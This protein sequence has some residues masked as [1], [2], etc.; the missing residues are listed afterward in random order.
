MSPPIEDD[1]IDEDEEDRIVDESSGPTV[2]LT[3]G[4]GSDSFV[5]GDDVDHIILSGTIGQASDFL[6]EDAATFNRRTQS[7][8]ASSTVMISAEGM[9]LM[10]ATAVELITI[11]A[12]SA[13]DTLTIKGDF[14]ST[15]LATGGVTFNGCGDAILDLDHLTSDLNVKVTR[16]NEEDDVTPE[17][18]VRMEQPR[19]RTPIPK[20][21]RTR[22]PLPDVA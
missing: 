6:I 3:V 13:D 18:T 9:L 19:L 1:W 15:A 22:E 7:T 8:M 20:L 10:S 2:R 17:D 21:N 11:D 5:G 4:H 12:G 14:S 16:G